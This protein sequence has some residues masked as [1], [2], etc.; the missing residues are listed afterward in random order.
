MSEEPYWRFPPPEPESPA[1]KVDDYAEE[2]LEH[3][4]EAVRLRLMSDVPLGAM[5]SG[6]LD[7]SLIVALMAE[8]G[9]EPVETFSV[10]F[11]EDGDLNEL[12][13][14]RRVGEAFGCNHHDLEL[15]LRDAAVGLDDLV[16]Y[17]DEPVA[18]L[19]AVGF[20]ALSR[21]ATQHVTVA[22]SG[23]GADELFGGYR[24][25]R[26]AA[27]LRRLD[28]LPVGVRRL[29]GQPL[30]LAPDR[31]KRLSPVLSTND[32]V[33]RQLAMSGHVDGK[34]RATLYAGELA[35]VDASYGAVTRALDGAQGDA[36]LTS[37]F[38]DGQLALVDNMLHYF[39][40]MSMAASLEVRVPFLD[41]VLVEWAAKLPSSVRVDGR[42]T[43]K[44]VLRRAAARYLP[45]DI[46]NRPKVGFFR[47]SA[48]AW[49]RA[50]L[51]GEPGESLLDPSRPIYELVD[52]TEV[53]RLVNEFRASE[54][55]EGTQLVLA[56]LVLDAWLAEF[57]PRATAA[58][59]TAA[60]R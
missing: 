18:E 34:T 25:H 7:S 54:R 27:V 50:Q 2:L 24:K 9:N 17:L 55:W 39:D 42:L 32:P 30:R 5:L 46:I 6:G 57:L 23:Q 59:A 38:L 36:L 45:P 26:V 22:L 8:A 49:L 43:T 28:V 40:R 52:R 14:A 1:R 48:A 13:Y 47:N 58:T 41:H 3:L 33:A 11:V 53:S 29:I 12:P 60:T 10:G 35:G 21:L 31:L 16:W 37:M 20:L 44:V 56:I 15:S 19:S 4:R 51:E